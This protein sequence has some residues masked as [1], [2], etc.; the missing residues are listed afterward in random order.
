[1]HSAHPLHPSW[2][3][4]TKNPFGRAAIASLL[5]PDAEFDDC[6]RGRLRSTERPPDSNLSDSE[7]CSSSNASRCTTISPRSTATGPMVNRRSASGTAGYVVRLLWTKESLFT[8]ELV[9]W[10]VDMTMRAS[11]LAGLPLDGSGSVASA[12][13]SS[14]LL[15]AGE[16]LAPHSR[17]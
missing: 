12:R 8:V 4:C 13:R 6:G 5:L 3:P 9:A 10:R 1:M 15:L 14:F 11:V 7:Y 17:M 2:S 16:L